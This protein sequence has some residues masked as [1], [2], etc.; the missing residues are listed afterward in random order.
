V[1]LLGDE[2]DGEVRAALWVARLA[3]GSRGIPITHDTAALILEE[4][5]PEAHAWTSSASETAALIRYVTLEAERAMLSAE[6]A[7]DDDA[8]LLQEL[9]RRRAAAYFDRVLRAHQQPGVRPDLLLSGARMAAVSGWD[10]AVT[11]YYKRLKAE[12]PDSWQRKAAEELEP[13]TRLDAGDLVP[14]VALPALD[15]AAPALTPAD[16]AGPA[17]LVDFWAVWCTPCVAELPNLRAA[18][19]R[20]ADR[21]LRIVSVS[22]DGSRET[23][24]AFMRTNPMPWQH[25]FVGAAELADGEVAAAYNISALPSAVLVGPAG[26]ILATTAALRGDRLLETLERVLPSP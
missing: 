21:G 26:Q 11:T 3:A 2:E 4:V 8:P 23:V 9:A 25:A 20:F 5:P 10:D 15:S 24:R 12:F 6:A 1:A 13:D 22:F 7:A 18:H 17:T 19:A 14:D 16:L